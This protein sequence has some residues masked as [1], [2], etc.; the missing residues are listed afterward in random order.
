MEKSGKTKC[1]NMPLRD[2]YTDSLLNVEL[3]GRIIPS[4]NS[5]RAFQTYSAV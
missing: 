4:E 3:L 2:F 1:V 5:C